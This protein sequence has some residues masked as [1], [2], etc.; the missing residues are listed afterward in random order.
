MLD[1]TRSNADRSASRPR[2]ASGVRSI[3]FSHRGDS[4]I[5]WKPASEA[6]PKTP[7]LCVARGGLRPS[8][9]GGKHDAGK[10]ELHKTPFT[11]E[12][13][14]PATRPNGVTCFTG[15][16]DLGCFGTFH[17]SGWANG[18]T[19]IAN[20]TSEKDQGVFRMARVSP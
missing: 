9:A 16:A 6:H 19:F 3:T 18:R 2:S 14:H 7:P 4:S 15:E 13:G 5:P 1:T 8:S 17:C 12:A 20:D 11:Y 10:R